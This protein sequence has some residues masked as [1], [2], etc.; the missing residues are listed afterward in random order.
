LFSAKV[1]TVFVPAARFPH[2]KAIEIRDDV[3]FLQ[4][5]KAVLTKNL[6]GACRS[7]K[8]IDH[9]VRQI[10]SRAVA[11]DEVIDIFAAAGLKNTQRL[12]WEHFG[13]LLLGERERYSEG[14]SERKVI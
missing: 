10:V 1:I 5:V 12:R 9:A 6:D 14:R 8:E 11:S 4:A 13:A 3:S 2:G 7:P